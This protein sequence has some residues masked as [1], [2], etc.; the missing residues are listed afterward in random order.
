MPNEQKQGTASTSS[1][2]DVVNQYTGEK[3][4]YSDIVKE[5]FFHPRNL[6]LEDPVAGQYNATGKVGSPACLLPDTNVITNPDTKAITDVSLGER[7]LSHDSKYHAV[8]RIFR[9]TYPKTSLVRLKNYLGTATLT[10]DHLV[11]GKRIPH[12]NG[13]HRH[14]FRFQVKF[15]R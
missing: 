10:G 15:V 6:L 14:N 1:P 8:E 3:W 5:H 9:V 12:G 2:V 11:Y 13:F 7:V 4:Y